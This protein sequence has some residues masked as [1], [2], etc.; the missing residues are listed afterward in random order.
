MSNVFVGIDSAVI[1]LLFGYV[2]LLMLNLF[3]SWRGI[4]DF[5]SFLTSCQPA[6][7]ALSSSLS[8][9]HLLMNFGELLN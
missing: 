6:F 7:P 4:D 2:L 8:R 9:T 3:V 1:S 5:A